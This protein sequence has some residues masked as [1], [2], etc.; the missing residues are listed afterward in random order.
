MK[1]FLVGYFLCLATVAGFYYGA[2]TIGDAVQYV[3]V[4]SCE[5]IRPSDLR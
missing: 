1:S 5:I 2:Q 4:N 3:R